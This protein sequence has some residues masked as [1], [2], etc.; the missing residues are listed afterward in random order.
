MSQKVVTGF[1]RFLLDK[2]ASRLRAEA[3]E[4]ARNL[5]LI[6][7]HK[8]LLIEYIKGIDDHEDMVRKGRVWLMELGE[9]ERVYLPGGSVGRMLYLGSNG[10]FYVYG[11]TNFRCKT[12]WLVRSARYG[13]DSSV[14]MKLR[15]LPVTDN[16]PSHTVRL[17]CE[18][19]LQAFI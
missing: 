5:N 18:R 4:M 9:L 12:T 2:E 6:A 13:A 1:T 7:R 15:Q 14:R 8:P 11:P 3:L 16:T 10:Q 17:V 19:V